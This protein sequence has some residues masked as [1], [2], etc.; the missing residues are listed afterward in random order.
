MQHLMLMFFTNMFI[1]IASTSSSPFLTNTGHN[2]LTTPSASP[3]PPSLDALVSS[4][5]IKFST[6]NSPSSLNLVS[7]T[8]NTD[9]F[10]SF[11]TFLNV[12]I[13]GFK[14]FALT[15]RNL[16]DVLR[17]FGFFLCLLF[18]FLKF[19]LILFLMLCFL[20]ILKVVLVFLWLLE[21]PKYYL[22]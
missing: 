20:V 3:P 7:S 9:G 5:I 14:P 16:I 19:Y 8:K 1:D 12:K 22:L 11:M 4:N 13:R 10:R 17:L 6:F 15:P 18:P 21:K 2:S